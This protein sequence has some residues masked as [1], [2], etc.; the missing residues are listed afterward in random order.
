[1]VITTL[2]AIGDTIFFIDGD[3]SFSANASGGAVSVPTIKT[4]TISSIRV[5]GALGDVHKYLIDE[6][7]KI[8]EASEVFTSYALAETAIRTESDTLLDTYYTP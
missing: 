4:G 1:M 6:Y 3:V 5:Y 8:L 2:H 7:N